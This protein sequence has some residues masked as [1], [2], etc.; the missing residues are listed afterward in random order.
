MKELLYFRNDS[1]HQMTRNSSEKFTQRGISFRTHAAL[2]NEN[3]MLS[4]Y[5]INLE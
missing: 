2:L 5:K 3:F 4:V 1:L